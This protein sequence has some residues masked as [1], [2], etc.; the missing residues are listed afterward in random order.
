MPTVIVA[1]ISFAAYATGAVLARRR[2]PSRVSVPVDPIE[3]LIV[4]GGL[5]LIV[6]LPHAA[7]SLTYVLVCALLGLLLG[8]LTA[9]ATLAR[10]KGG[11][12]GTREFEDI[13]APLRPTNAWKRWL[14]F[15]RSVADYEIRL[16]LVA[17]YLLIIGPIGVAHRLARATPA[18][19][20]SRSNWL[21]R[22]DRATLDAA[23]RS[24]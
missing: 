22:S 3:V 9:T 23:R 8:A 1:V 18:N 14:S 12:G 19:D 20:G 16:L 6:A 24:F 10:N 13:P 7:S 5:L 11:G 2:L 4:S 15:T 21:P 17:C